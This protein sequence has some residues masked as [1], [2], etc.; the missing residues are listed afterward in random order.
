MF[1]GQLELE[2]AEIEQ[3]SKYKEFLKKEKAALAEW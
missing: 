3:V 2:D 1:D